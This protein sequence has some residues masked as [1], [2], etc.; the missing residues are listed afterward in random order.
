MEFEWILAEYQH[1]KQILYVSGLASNEKDPVKRITLELKDGRSFELS[2]TSESTERGQVGFSGRITGLEAKEGIN[3]ELVFQLC[4]DALI[5][6]SEPVQHMLRRDPY[7]KLQFRFYDMLKS[8][9]SGRILEIGSRNLSGVTRREMIPDDMEY[10]GFDIMEGEN[11]ALVG[12]V[13]NLSKIVKSCSFDAVFSISV[14]EHLIMPWKAAVEINRVLKTGG[15]FMAAT[16]QTFPIHEIPNDFFRFS[17][18]AWKGLF[19]TE[20]GFE[21]IDAVMGEKAFISGNYLHQVTAGM[22]HAMAYLGSCVLVK[23]IGESKVDWPVDSDRIIQKP[24][25]R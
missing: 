6:I 3:A 21:I 11:V 13:H 16:H 7:H 24:Y 23:K 9:K 15:L 17:D 4:S 5:R 1:I 10:V 8:I 18:N 20:T 25:P 2:I 12:D 19:N 22:E 14:F